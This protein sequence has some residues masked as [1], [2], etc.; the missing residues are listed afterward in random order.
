MI[1]HD[2]VE[3]DLVLDSKG[4]IPVSLISQPLSTRPVASRMGKVTALVQRITYSVMSKTMHCVCD[5]G[6]A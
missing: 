3:K 6:P 1:N 4:V 5:F 2:S